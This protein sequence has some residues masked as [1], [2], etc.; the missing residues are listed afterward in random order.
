MV[1]IKNIL[2]DSLVMHKLPMQKGEANEQI[3]D[4]HIKYIKYI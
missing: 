3:T 2:E 4:W 1:Y